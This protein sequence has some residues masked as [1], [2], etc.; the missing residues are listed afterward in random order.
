LGC[1]RLSGV[2]SDDEYIRKLDAAVMR[3]RLNKEWRLEYMTIEQRDM[4]HERVGRERGREEGLETGIKTVVDLCKS[5]GGSSVDAVEKIVA[6][7]GF[8]QAEADRLVSKYW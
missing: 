3:G 5:L 1:H 7:M 8:S 6:T 2:V 4:E